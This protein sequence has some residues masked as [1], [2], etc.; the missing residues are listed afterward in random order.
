MKQLINI[1]VLTTMFINTAFADCPQ[2]VTLL[3]KDSPAPCKGYLFSPSKE[4]E[5]RVINEDNKILKK[6]VENKDKQ[7]KLLSTDINDVEAIVSKEREKSELWRGRAE[8]STKKL[9]ESESGRGTRDL[10]MVIG[11]V[12]LTVGAGFAIGAAAKR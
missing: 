1:L 11:G 6:T 8:D 4:L 3:E 5:V 7:I 12:L 9:I 10:L 2:P